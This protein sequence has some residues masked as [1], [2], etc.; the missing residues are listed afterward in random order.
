MAD[1]VFRCDAGASMGGGHAV[2]CLALAD[3]LRDA[4]WTATFAS[5][6]E[7]IDTVPAIA[8]SGRD[9]IELPGAADGEPRLLA[10]KLPQGCDALIVDH[11]GR[12]GDFET[13]CRGFA[14]RIF[15]IDDIPDRAHDCDLLL[16]ATPGRK[17]DEYAR[18]VPPDCKL[19]MGGR[20]ALLRRQFSEARAAAL[21]RRGNGEEV[22]RIL[23]SMG[24]TDPSDVTSVVLRGIARSGLKAAVDV[25]MGQASPHLSK[26]RALVASRAVEAHVH[27]EVSDVA[28]LMT[29]ADV[30]VG[31]AGASSFERCCLG[32]PSLVVV[33]AANQRQIA[34]ALVGAGAAVSLGEA[35]TLRE[36]DVA[37]ALRNLAADAERRAKLARNAGM[38][39]DGRGAARAA[40]AI[41]P[42]R[43]ADGKEVALRP[44][45]TADRN[46]M[47]EWQRH[48][49]TRRYARDPAVPA[50]AEHRA[51]LEDRLADPF[52]LFN[53][54]MHGNDSAG[55][56]RL[57][58]LTTEAPTYEVSILIAPE[59]HKL[60]L[61][62]AALR[63]AARLAP[64]AELFAEVHPDNEASNSLFLSAGFRRTGGAYRHDPLVRELRP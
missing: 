5:T 50:E 61:G 22:S 37:A 6:R 29:A 42:E 43:A 55:V 53:I 17:A 15:A 35:K 30:A 59:K 52:C 9:W 38:L 58:R 54:V 40:V 41:S 14:K 3:A 32:L 33:A 1:A 46:I 27:V 36:D 62:K 11:Y 34:A 12:G 28:A 4:G 31:A 8:R 7:T 10:A 19:L 23:V 16:D 20:Y 63:L 64:E 25:V 57:E 48:P 13:A 49:V 44:A 56:L 2:R 47:L 26:V 39:C 21:A 60:G 51:W 18:L 24:A 45:T